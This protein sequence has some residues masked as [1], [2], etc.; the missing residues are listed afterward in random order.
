[1]TA[2]NLDVRFPTD[3]QRSYTCAIDVVHSTEDGQLAAES[4]ISL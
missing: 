2:D 4:V 1:M 3:I